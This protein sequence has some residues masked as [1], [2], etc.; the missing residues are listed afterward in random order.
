MTRRF[1]ENGNV[2]CCA[3]MDKRILPLVNIYKS[4]LDEI[5]VLTGQSDLE[6]AIESSA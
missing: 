1:D 6:K 2:T 4:S 3:Q 5:E